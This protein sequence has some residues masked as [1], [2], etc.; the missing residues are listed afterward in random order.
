MSMTWN[1]EDYK[2]FKNL[3]ASE[4]QN[5]IE[6]GWSTY[7]PESEWSSPKD[8]V[9]DSEVWDE[10]DDYQTQQIEGL[11]AVTVLDSVGGS[12]GGGEYAHKIVRVS[13]SQGDHRFFQKPGWYQSY[14]GAHWDGD[15]FEVA[16]VQ[17]T[18][19]VWEKVK[20]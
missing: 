18:V 6:A 1:V 4:I 16:P 19:T 15:L 11:G 5:L 3:S 7:D 10:W 8:R 20:P 2:T 12:E 13:N 9:E 17:R 14:D